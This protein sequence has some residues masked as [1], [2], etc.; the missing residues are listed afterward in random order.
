VPVP[1]PKCG[2][3]VLGIPTS[4]DPSASAKGFRLQSFDY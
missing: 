4:T 3:I 2:N 1:D